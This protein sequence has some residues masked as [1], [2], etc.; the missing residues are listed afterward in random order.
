MSLNKKVEPV[1]VSSYLDVSMTTEDETEEK[2]SLMPATNPVG[3]CEQNDQVGYY[4]THNAHYEPSESSEITVADAQAERPTIV[5]KCLSI[6]DKQELIKGYDDLPVYMTTATKCQ[7]LGV[8]ISTLRS[9]LSQ[10]EKI[11]SI[12]GPNSTEKKLA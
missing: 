12:Q 3:G 1:N 6:R 11:F 7:A 9:V 8:N 10:R 2:S 5:R 4:H